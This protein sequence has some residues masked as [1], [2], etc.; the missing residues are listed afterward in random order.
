[1]QHLLTRLLECLSLPYALD[2]NTAYTSVSVGATFFPDDAQSG[3][4]LLKNADAAMFKAKEMG[5]NTYSFFTPEMN[6]RAQERHTLEVALHKALDKKHFLLHYQ[7]IVDPHTQTVVSTEA[8]VRWN[9]PEKGL[10]SPDKFIPVAEDTGLIV[11]MGEWILRQACTDAAHWQ[12]EE[13]FNIGV[14][15][16]LSSRQFM[17]SDIY[18]LVKDVLKESQLPASKLTLEITE[19]LLV[20]D[21]NEILKTLRK[22][23]DLGVL[24]SIDDFGTG[25]SSLSYLKRF[26]ITT[27][28]IDRSFIC[29]ILSDSEDSPDPS[30]SFNGKEHEPKS[31][32]RR[33]GKRRAGRISKRAPMRSYPRFLL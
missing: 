2:G 22:L 14:S 27:L 19:S 28:K 25:Y 13:G 10:I 18:G 6:N 17:R 3:D 4:N 29:D 32:G 11:P 7:P 1:M 33:C 24:L 5:R 23:R 8:L 15:V 20:E 30:H 21:E 31:R 16:N 12:K 9:D 26:P